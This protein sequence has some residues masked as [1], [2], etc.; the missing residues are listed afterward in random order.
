MSQ[1]K[2]LVIFRISF[3]IICLWFSLI[4]NLKENLSGALTNWCCCCCFIV[5]G[6]FNNLPH[7]HSESQVRVESFHVL[8]I[9]VVQSMSNVAAHPHR[10]LWF[11]CAP[12]VLSLFHGNLDIEQQPMRLNLTLHFGIHFIFFPGT[13]FVSG[14]YKS[15]EK[16]KKKNLGILESKVE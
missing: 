4:S 7:H 15:I 3:S 13:K 12:F 14:F 6:F 5:F 9:D 8:C 10:Y 11:S 1:S 2:N 16:K